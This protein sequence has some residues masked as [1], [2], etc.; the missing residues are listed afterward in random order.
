MF[1]ARQLQLV[2]R[3][4]LLLCTTQIPDVLLLQSC[5]NKT[6][7]ISKR[8]RPLSSQANSQTLI[9]DDGLTLNDFVSGRSTTKPDAAVVVHQEKMPTNKEHDLTFHLKTYGCQMNVSD[10]DI[11]RSLLLDASFRECDDEAEASI[12]LTNTCA[13]REGAEAKVW[14]RMRELRG[15]FDNK[16][17]RR[18][19][20]RPNKVVGV[21]GCM[22]ERLKEELFKDGLAD[23]V[24]GPDAYRDLPRLLQELAAEERQ[25]EKAVNVQLSLEETYADITPVRK[26]PDDVSAF[27][28]IQRG[29]ANRCS[30][31]IVPFTRGQERSRPFQSIVDEVRALYDEGVKEVT[32]LGQNVNSYH[33][34]SAEAV[35]MMPNNDYNM[36][37]DGFRSRI[38]RGGDGYWFHDLVEA[39][40]SVSPELR[41]RFTSPHPK[42]YPTELLTLMAER[43]NVCNSLHMPAQSGSTSV[44][45]R[46]KRGYSRETYLELMENVHSIIP[47]VAITSDFIS[48]FCDESE[49]EHQ[50]TISL[51]QKVQYDQAF[52]FAYSLREKT[53][54]HKVMEDSVPEEV[55]QRRLREVIDTFRYEVQRKNVDKELGRLRLVLIEGESKRSKPGD[56]NYGG[57]TDQNK[58]I[59]FPGDE[60]ACTTFS[61]S[62]LKQVMHSS[63]TGKLDWSAATRV[64][65]QP[66]DYA[67]AEVTEVKG[68][69][70]RGRLLCRS[71]IAA[72]E[73]S[74]LS[75]LDEMSLHEANLVKEAFTLGQHVGAD[76][77]TQASQKQKCNRSRV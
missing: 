65:L 46:M 19:K 23:L 50:D 12:L 8:Q 69:G 28:S 13:I 67:I 77:G 34:Q 30:F 3:R 36:S 70:L 18:R 38:R 61:E 1:L 4:K 53:H 25:V 59:L 76:F 16:H 64:Y 74:G 58:R 31:C 75:N 10:S 29:C 21:L 44:L 55:K 60:D 57:R 27:V 6:T 32:L 41:V 62:T 20:G 45:K 35:A 66:G 9:P 39:V 73:E 15:R 68:P 52:M 63:G 42:D 51:L 49:E 40:S 47:D 17:K 37:N 22:A 48:G 5:T 11:V 43:P 14:H 7:N 2:A 72:F 33:D 56:R 71:S 24:V 54:A 26:N